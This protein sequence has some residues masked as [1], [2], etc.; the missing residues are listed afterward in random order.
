MQPSGAISRRAR[1]LVVEKEAAQMRQLCN[2]LEQHGYASQGTT[3]GQQALE[4]LLPGGQAAKPR[5]GIFERL[6]RSDEFAGRGMSLAI[7][8]QVLSR[9]AGQVCALGAP[10]RGA[11]FEFVIPGEDSHDREGLF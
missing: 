9:H 3:N 1:C 4:G 5:I 2:A 10:K 7:V 6:H 8:K 11:C